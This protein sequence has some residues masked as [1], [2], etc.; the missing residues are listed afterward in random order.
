MIN[1]RTK[2][3]YPNLPSYI[4]C[5]KTIGRNNNIILN[6]L[7]YKIFTSSLITTEKGL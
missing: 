1:I 5:D 7:I 2:T 3:K 6:F 4:K